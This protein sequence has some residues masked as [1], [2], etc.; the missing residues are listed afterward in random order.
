M[1]ALDLDPVR[2]AD[3]DDIAVE[4]RHEHGGAEVA[5]Q[6]DELG[7]LLERLG[8]RYV[9]DVATSTGGRH[10]LVLFA[11]ALPWRELRDLCR[12][13]ALRFPAVDSAPMCS[14]SA[15]RSRPRAQG[16][17]GAAGACCLRP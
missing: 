8:A 15:A 17:S 4:Q 16:R 6:A 11:A 3:V 10:V 12:A 2:A 7:Q 9:A 13:I 5:R 14:A 1:L